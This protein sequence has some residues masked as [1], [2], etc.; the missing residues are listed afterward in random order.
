MR[1]IIPF[2][3]AI[4]GCYRLPALDYQAG[5]VIDTVLVSS[6]KSESYALYLPS[7]Y[8]T[9]SRWPVLYF[10]EPGGRGSL[11]VNTY[12]ALAEANGIIMI[13]SN[14]SRN[15]LFEKMEPIAKRVF[16]DT[17][18]KFRIDTGHIYCAGFSGGAKLAFGLAKKYRFI[19]AVISCG[20]CYPADG[21]DKKDIPFIN[22]GIIGT[23]DMNYYWMCR[24]KI[25]MDSIGCPFHLMLFEGEHE[26]PPEESFKEALCWTM[27]KDHL[28]GNTDLAMFFDIMLC[29]ANEAFN[30]KSFFGAYLRAKEMQR[31]FDSTVYGIKADSLLQS[32][33]EDPLYLAQINELD[34]ISK[35]EAPL[36][37]KISEAFLAMH[38]TAY[39]IPD[40]IYTAAWWNFLHK[41]IQKLS[42]TADI[43]P[44]KLG[45]RLDGLIIVSAWEAGQ[46][47]ME[48]KDYE[49]A[50]MAYNVITIFRPESWYGYRQLSLCYSQMHQTKKAGKYHEIALKKGYKPDPGQ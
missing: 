22:C 12:A 24:Q 11:P 19:K 25:I 28:K 30:Q 42:G 37:N 48:E 33:A 46:A 29:A 15:G 39:N 44:Q 20:A 43:E 4:A 32:I 27:Y 31:I 3:L 40:T 47:Y 7:D 26:W 13:C 41:K 16:D 1:Q 38:L 6:N 23:S 9:K 14:N 49:R 2:I 50:V 36:Q 10:F 21:L 35:T 8:N 45:K 18:L 17:R 34:R 5:K